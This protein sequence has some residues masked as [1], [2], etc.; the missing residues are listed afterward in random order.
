[1]LFHEFVNE[2]KIP[3]LNVLCFVYK[4][5]DL[6]YEINWKRQVLFDWILRNHLSVFNLFIIQKSL[7]EA[8]IP[9]APFFQNIKVISCTPKVFFWKQVDNLF[10][11]V[12]EIE[13]L[14]DPP[15]F[16]QNKKNVG[17]DIAKDVDQNWRV[18][19]FY[20]FPWSLHILT[21]ERL[22]VCIPSQLPKWKLIF[23]SELILNL[24]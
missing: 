23:L 17:F 18:H 14:W 13:N 7:A 10:V 16:C 12:Y 9:L 11:F 6:V 5:V 22:L 3:N 19:L 20:S 21:I 8:H 4:F 2:L 15:H 1:M 24:F